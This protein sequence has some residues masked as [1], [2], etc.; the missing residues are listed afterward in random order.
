MLYK[1]YKCCCFCAQSHVGFMLPFIKGLAI[2]SQIFAV[3]SSA[4]NGNS[5]AVCRQLNSRLCHR[6]LRRWFVP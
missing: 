6:A 4:V 1:A 2:P 3:I 5:A